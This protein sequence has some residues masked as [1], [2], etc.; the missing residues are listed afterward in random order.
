MSNSSQDSRNGAPEIPNLVQSLALSLTGADSFRAENSRGMGGPR[1]FGGQVIAQAL[2]AAYGTVTDRPCHSLHA[3]FVRPGSPTTPIDFN[4]ERVREGTSFT[5]RRVTAVQDGE[6][7]LNLSASFQVP[8]EGLT[9]QSE[10]PAAPP[11]ESLPEGNFGPPVP[12]GSGDGPFSLMRPIEM[13][14]VNPRSFTEPDVSPP[15][16]SMW[17]R[18]P[19]LAG[20]PLRDHHVALA[21]ASD[22]NV[23][24]TAM[25]PAWTDL[26]HAGIP[27]RQP[28]P[29]AVAAPA[30]RF[31]AVASV[32]AR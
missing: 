3:Y 15:H 24:E 1:L 17:I 14:Q 32:R 26:V 19:S 10:M 21:F 8:E 30:V 6:Q 11:A 27:I 18:T 22:M 4:V 7:I 29:C 5:T 16:K 25:R 2:L 20:K 28:R 13:R 23:L 31:F 12:A 9:H